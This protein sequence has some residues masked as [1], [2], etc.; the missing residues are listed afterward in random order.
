[1]SKSCDVTENFALGCRVIRNIFCAFGHYFVP[2][3]YVKGIDLTDA[4]G[5]LS[6]I[7]GCTM[8]ENETQKLDSSA[9]VIL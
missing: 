1:M 7:V 8:I 2:M 4:D 9:S 6:I 5:C 3:F